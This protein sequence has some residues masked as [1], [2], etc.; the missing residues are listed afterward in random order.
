MLY[1]RRNFPIIII[2]SL[3]LVF[4]INSPAF[5][6]MDPGAGSMILQA[7]LGGIAGVAVVLK[8]YW[9]KFKSIFHRRAEGVGSENDDNM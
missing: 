5:A 8:I 1:R 3:F 7:L 9:Y 2:F 6:Y 4:G